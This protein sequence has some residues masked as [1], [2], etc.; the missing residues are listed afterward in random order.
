MLPPWHPVTVMG[1]GNGSNRCQALEGM[2]SL[3]AFNYAGKKSVSLITA[4]AKV[5][6]CHC[7]ICKA[8]KARASSCFLIT[9]LFLCH[10]RDWEYSQRKGKGRAPLLTP[11]AQVMA[12]A[13]GITCKI[14]KQSRIWLKT[15]NSKQNSFLGPSCGLSVA[16]M[17]SQRSSSELCLCS[18]ALLTELNTS[19]RAA[20]LPAQL[21]LHATHELG[22][23]NDSEISL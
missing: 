18:S 14:K 3:R 17:G 9:P 8:T 15:T 4:G 12:E 7:S 19:T 21:Y 22:I 23:Y 10:G 5:I 6:L 11:Q 16:L 1:T 13:N 20:T 2:H